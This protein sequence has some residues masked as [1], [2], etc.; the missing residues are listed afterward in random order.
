MGQKTATTPDGRGRLMGQPLRVAEMI[1]QLDGPVYVE[2]VA[3]YDN[4]QRVKAQKAIA[5]AIRLQTEHRGFAMVEVLSECPLHLGQTPQ[6]AER[7]VKERMVPVFPLG[8]KKDETATRDPWPDWKRPSFDPAVVYGLVG[9]AA[10]PAPRFCAAFPHELWGDG[11]GLKLAGAGGDGAQTV[12]MIVARAA[13]AEGFDATAIPSYGPESRGGTSYADVRIAEGDVLSPA[14]PSPHVLV[15]FNAPSLA[16]FGPA[17]AG[18]GVIVYDSSVIAD[19]PAHP[20]VRMVPVPATAIARD[21]GAVMVK[22]IVVLGAL[23]EATRLFPRATMLTA[24]RRAFGNKAAAL[25]LNER[26]F[27]EG[28]RAAGDRPGDGEGCAEAQADG[29]PCASVAATCDTCGRRRPT[30]A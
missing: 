11:I 21:L 17:V 16:K 30:P 19:A 2:R 26:A 13:I 5:K 24:L 12:A 8:V 3:L 10:E 29:V 22:N 23:A 18:G 7:W 14:V 6:E 4:K 20:A 1:A 25:E 27:D 15:A 28:A 9:G